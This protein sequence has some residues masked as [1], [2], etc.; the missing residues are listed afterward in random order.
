MKS[1]H[2]WKFAAK[3]FQWTSK[4]RHSDLHNHNEKKER[5]ADV[6]REIL[7]ETQHRETAK[8]DFSILIS[9]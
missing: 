3:Q 4:K 1:M 8:Q 2:Q 9:H 6:T 5:A 7:R